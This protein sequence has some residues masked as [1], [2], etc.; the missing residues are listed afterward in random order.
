MGEEQDW[1]YSGSVTP[2]SLDRIGD[3]LIRYYFANPNY[4]KID[5]KAYFSIYDIQRF[6]E[7]F[8]TLENTRKTMD[9]LQEKA[10]SAGLKGVHWNL[11]AWGMPQL[12]GQDAPKDIPSLIERLGFDSA[13][14]YV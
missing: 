1:L 9:R 6:I 7:G 11:V 13:T 4:W 5:G 10:I 2:E 8:G 12:P 3:E 14:S